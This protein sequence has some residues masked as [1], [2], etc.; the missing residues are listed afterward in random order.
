MKKIKRLLPI[1]LTIAMGATATFALTACDENY[2]TTET[3]NLIAELQATINANKNELD[4]KIDALTE[5]YK[6]KDDELLAKITANENAIAA[7]QA[8]YAEKLAELE[9]AEETNTKAISDLKAEYK[10]KVEELAKSDTDNANALAELKANYES[11]VTALEKADGDNKQAI[12]DLEKEYLAEVEKL[13]KADT[14]NE[15]AIVEL[16]TAYE[17]KVAALEKANENNAKAITSLKNE[18][19]A[20]LTSLERE[21]ASANAAIKSNKTEL[22]GAITALTA[23]YEAKMT[24]IDALL[25]T[26]QN[27]DTTQDE[28]IAELVNKIAALEEA[29]RITGVQFANNGDLIITF[30]DG[31]TQT[32]K[33]PEEH[34]HTFGEWVNFTKGEDI[35]CE[36]RLFYHIC[37]ECNTIEWKQGAYEDHDWEIVTTLPTCQAQGYNT[38]TCKDC[39][40]V[41]INEYTATVAHAW[42][43]EYSVNNSY[44]WYDCATCDGVNGKEEHTDDGNGICSI[45]ECPLGATEGILYDISADG[46]ASVLGYEGT[47]TR[48]RIAD[49]YQGAPVTNIHKNAF[50][51]AAFKEII[52]PDSVTTIGDSAFV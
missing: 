37:T 42:S 30:G 21:I 19:S 22:N 44:H 7:M 51:G 48:V 6:A 46:N 27:A 15:N 45:C 47:A 17:S 32:V 34:V 8:E 25:E 43:Q 26:I 39:G 9:F 14:K 28:K 3:D 35:S 41:E 52:I 36:D 20:K 12:A 29:T 11:K 33:A 13:A 50:K 49:T 23:T 1:M 24:Q 18:H 16:K 10:A 38:N 2:T 5:E 40:K 4:G 31:S